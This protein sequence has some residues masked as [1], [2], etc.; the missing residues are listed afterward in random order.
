M[1]FNQSLRFSN[2]EDFC[3]KFAGNEISTEE[4][5]AKIQEYFKLI[6]DQPYGKELSKILK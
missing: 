2:L 6:A 5:E 1:N 4:Y 3:E